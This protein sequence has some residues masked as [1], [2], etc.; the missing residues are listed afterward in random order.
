M[1]AAVILAP[2][3]PAIARAEDETQPAIDF[4]RQ[5]RPILSSKC[6][7]CH[8]PDEDQREGD[9]RLDVAEVAYGR[10]IVPGDANASKLIHRITSRDPD[11][12]MPP[13]DSKLA[14]TPAEISL[15]EQWVS[16]GAE[17][18]LH[19]AFAKPQQPAA[20]TPKNQLWSRNEIDKFLL[21]RLEDEALDPSPE[22]DKVTL[23]RRLSFDLTGLPPTIEEVDRFLVDERPRAYESL[24]DRLLA[25]QHYGERMAQD[26]LDL[27]RYGDT[28]GYEND[29]DRQMWLYRDWI[30][31]ALNTNLPFDQF[32][33]EQIAGDLLPHA[34]DSQRI[35]SGFNRNT[36]YNEEGGADPEEFAV[37]YAVERAS[38]TATVFLGLTMG[39]AQCHDHK[40]DP[41]SQKEFYQFYAFFNSVDGEKGATGHDI[42][43]PPLISLATKEQTVELDRTRRELAELATRIAEAVARVEVAPA[44]AGAD[45]TRAD[46][47]AGKQAEKE[48]KDAQTVKYFA[49]QAAW[50]EHEMQ[51]Q[52]KSKLPA[53]VLM[54]VK[55]EADKRSSEQRQ[56]LRDY[57]VEHAY[58]QAKQIFEPLHQQQAN[59]K[60]QAEAIDKAVA[61]TMVMKKMEQRRPAHL[62]IRGDFQ[63]KGEQ[64]EPDVPAIFPPL[65]AQRARDRL[66]LAEWLV[67]EDNPLL[68]RV[69][70]NRLWKQFFGSGLVKT[71]EDFGVRGEYPSHPKLLDWLATEFVRSRWNVKALQKK[72]V[73]STTYR[74]ASRYRPDA[75]R[76]DP[77]NRLLARQN[78]FRFTAEGIRDTALAVA[79]LLNE[80]IGGPSVY[81]YQPADYY[82]DKG[83]WK[84]PQSKGQD[85]YRR[86]LYTYWRRTTT[87]PTFGIF[88]A[89]SRE[90]CTVE[91]PRTN[92][93]LQALV[94]LNDPTFVEAARVFAERI[95]RQGGTST[96]DRLKFAFR[97]TLARSPDERDCEILRGVY[98]D[99][100]ANYTVAT[101]AASALVQQGEHPTPA[102]LDP[103]QLAA[104]TNIANVLLNLDETITRE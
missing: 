14:L 101:Q 77:Y 20:P 19:W 96:D 38:T 97:A 55:L 60:K 76:I 79:G 102:D 84:W 103:I 47:V 24:V 58:S 41:I 50:E 51:Q 87:Y 12:Q 67:D 9:L 81:P 75:A 72:I 93:P 85:L 1:L 31:N 15:L 23:I 27:A 59:L 82:S 99:R 21:K 68:A 63:Q 78:R 92:T 45:Q 95:M 65:P 18:S 98:A 73:M 35:A 33:I 22:A 39:C 17:Y 26:W 30:I 54:L 29:S 52:E 70:V 80:D 66:A 3:V 43:L 13:P 28:N 2:Q 56:Q 16:Q 6:F 57:F 94:T 88:D 42:P 64:V 44:A 91:R 74:Q 25:S 11:K 40:Y 4:S 62:L 61:T 34:N 53:D 90:T 46:A 5:I 86:G 69:A 32:T 104:W 71:M 37:V 83:R 49:A 8:G 100:L 89:P 10:V 7:R 48:K 36:T